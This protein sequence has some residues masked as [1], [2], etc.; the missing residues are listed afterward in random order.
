MSETND[1]NR[2]LRKGFIMLAI[3]IW[4]LANKL[5]LFDLSY[6]TSWPLLLILIGLAM[7]LAPNIKERCNRGA[8]GVM[9]MIWGALF[10]VAVQGLWGFTWNNAWPIFVVGAGLDIT[11]RAIAEQR[12]GRG[13][14]DHGRD[15]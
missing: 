2:E 7:T 5:D 8:S 1:R 11:W 12:R 9:L 4:F 13:A 3:G 15:E 10:W 14:S 6:D